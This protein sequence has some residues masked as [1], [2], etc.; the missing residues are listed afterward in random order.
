MQ[1]ISSADTSLNQVPGTFKLAKRVVPGAWDPHQVVLDYGGGKY[2]KFTRLLESLGLTS[3]VF[4]PYNRT[5]D[6]NARVRRRL[7][8]KPADVAVLANVLNV[9]RER[10]VRQEILR[11][12]ASMLKPA[13]NLFITVHEGDRNSVGRKT[14]K[15]W[16][17]N[18]PT[19]N[20]LR[21]IRK[22]FPNAVLKAGGKLIHAQNESA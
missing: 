7:E 10:A 3:F 16:Q 5:E 12:L 17:T 6:H 8:R 21:E 1:A 19:K 20:Y 18:R 11:D 22:V 13:G 4:D 2:D 15:G 14:A 9:I